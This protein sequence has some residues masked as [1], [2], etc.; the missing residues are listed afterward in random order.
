MLRMPIST[1]S[2]H[3]ISRAVLLAELKGHVVDADHFAALRVDDLLVQQIAHQAQHVLVG[4]I[5]R[6][7]FVAQMNAIERNGVDLIV[8]HREQGPVAADQKTIDAD[9]VDQGNDGGVL[10]RHRACAP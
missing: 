9:R 10:A 5:G 6:E 1:S 3:R 8:T 4:M 7:V 2:T